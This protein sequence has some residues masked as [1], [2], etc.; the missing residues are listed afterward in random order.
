MILKTVPALGMM[1][2]SNMKGLHHVM[3]YHLLSD[4]DGYYEALAM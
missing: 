4:S 3:K 1:L 2:I